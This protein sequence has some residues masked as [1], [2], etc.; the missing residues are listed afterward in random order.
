MAK[1]LIKTSDECLSL[2]RM[3]SRLVSIVISEVLETVLTIWLKD[4]INWIEKIQ[5]QLKKQNNSKNNYCLQLNKNWVK[6]V[7]KT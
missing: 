7:T 2:D 1:I 6:T 5:K 4:K 3:S